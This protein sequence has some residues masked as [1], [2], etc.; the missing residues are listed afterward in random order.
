MLKIAIPNKGQLSDPAID[1]LK[2]AGYLAGFQGRNLKLVDGKNDV[3]FYFLR[4][5]DI[6]TYVSQGILDI[7]ITGQDM[8]IDSNIELTQILQLG[9]ARSFFALAGKNPNQKLAE[10]SGVRI[11]TSYPGLLGSW[12]AKNGISAEII[13]LEG[14]VENAVQLGVAD[15]VA[16]VVATGNTLNQ[17]GLSII[18]EPIMESEA[19]LVS[20]Q[21]AEITPEIEKFVRRLNSVI[22]ARDYV[23]MDYDIPT[24]LVE[25]ACEITPGFESPT[26]SALRDPNWSAI[27][28]MVR[29]AEVHDVMDQLYGKGAK[30]ILVTEIAACRL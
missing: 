30:G 6:A 24:S 28:V 5:K 1:M 13:K 15:F 12:L 16:D 27:R 29:A 7:G 9:F 4:P 19:V 20:R 18:G 2:E 21:N 14:A 25:T 3:E 8:V 23:L 26:I 17:A 10:L 11:A 22:V